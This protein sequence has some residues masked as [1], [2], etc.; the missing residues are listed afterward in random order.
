MSC[1]SDNYTASIFSRT[2]L[3]YADEAAGLDGIIP[4][5]SKWNLTMCKILG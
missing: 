5:H 4:T 1:V 3:L 2:K